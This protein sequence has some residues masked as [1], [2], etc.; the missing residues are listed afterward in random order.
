[1]RLIKTAVFY[2]FICAITVFTL[3]MVTGCNS[4]TEI[5]D[6]P[7]N[8][9]DETRVV[10]AKPTQAV[11]PTGRYSTQFVELIEALQ[12]SDQNP[13]LKEIVLAQW[14][15]ESAR[16]KSSLA[17]L[18]YNFG[19]LKWRDEMKVYAMPVLY[20][21]HD[22]ETRYCKFKSA[23]SFVRGYW[24]FI[25]R[26]PYKGW[27]KFESNPEEFL[28]FIV[29]SGYCPDNG[30]VDNVLNLRGEARLLLSDFKESL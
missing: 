11:L 14:I 12:K 8:M 10:E 25:N 21:A 20:G 16:G 19:G 26:Y 28:R 6:V 13:E 18:H 17:K 7:D 23:S 2:T 22:G 30:Y 15:L 4:K 27:R 29:L 24:H 3:D 9:P 5:Q 1:M